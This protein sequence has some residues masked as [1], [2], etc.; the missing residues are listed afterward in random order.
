MKTQ[1]LKIICSISLLVISIGVTA[2]GPQLSYF[3]N[4]FT[5]LP[6]ASCYINF[7][8]G[9][10]Q[11]IGFFPVINEKTNGAMGIENYSKDVN[12]NKGLVFISVNVA[13]TIN[14]DKESINIEDKIVMLYNYSSNKQASS[15]LTHLLEKEII[16]AI[17]KKAAAIV[18]ISR[19]NSYPL[20]TVNLE[21]EIP[22]ITITNKAAESIFSSAGIDYSE[23]AKKNGDKI[24][25][26]IELPVK[27]KLRIDGDFSCIETE[28]F[29]YRYLSNLFTEAEINQQKS[30]N[31][32]SIDFLLELFKE[33]KFEWSK[34]DIYYFSNYDSKIFYTGY[35]G[36]GFSCDIGVYNV[37]FNKDASYSLSVHENTH[38]MLRKNSLTFNS[39]FDEGIARYAEAIATNKDLNNK[40][41]FDFLTNGKL[42]T[43][44]KMLEFNI[45][46]NLYETEIGYPASGSFTEFL[47]EKYGLKIILKL[48]KEAANSFSK[49]DLINHEE[50]W[51]S[52]LKKEYNKK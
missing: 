40:K 2:Q 5:Q 51:L 24:P 38:S 8:K 29:K 1:V 6:W 13:D 20:F 12:I 27:I 41:T 32:E 3:H 10:K 11:K 14:Y 44:E 17:D 26:L 30:I 39:F 4:P 45:G 23:I 42:L 7:E 25:K 36:I 31:E 46:N 34:E 22:A 37:F 9:S 21:K 50:E 35:W 52:W 49:R 16:Y 18:V 48:N 15:Q 47:I 28:R 43:L 33:L 19:D